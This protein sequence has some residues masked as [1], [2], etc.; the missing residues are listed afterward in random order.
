MIFYFVQ[1]LYEGD[2][3][4]I[5]HFSDRAKADELVTQLRKYNIRASVV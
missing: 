3:A 4:T 1:V 2:V 5:A